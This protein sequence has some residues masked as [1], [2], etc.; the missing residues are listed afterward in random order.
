[1][2]QEFPTP[3]TPAPQGKSLAL[4]VPPNI[5]LE[6]LSNA[7]IEKLAIEMAQKVAAS[8]PPQSTLLG[9]DRLV[10]TNAQKPD[11]GVEVTWTRACAS[12]ESP[13]EGIAINPQAF[14]EP[15]VDIATFPSTKIVTD[16]SG[17]S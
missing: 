15:V 17:N 5:N 13:R 16:R 1:M 8:G 4:Q 11:V 3:A 7:E 14:A 9:V 10:L 12:A 6:N 2:A